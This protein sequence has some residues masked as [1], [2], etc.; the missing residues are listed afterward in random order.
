M[1]S[2]TRI[3]DANQDDQIIINVRNAR[4]V[5]LVF[6]NCVVD[7]FQINGVVFH[8]F[9]AQIDPTLEFPVQDFEEDF[10]VGDDTT[11]TQ[12]LVVERSYTDTAETQEMDEEVF[13]V[14]EEYERGDTQLEYTQTDI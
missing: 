10:I 9:E 4:N 14:D 13:D 12:E 8:R 6:A 11:D 3:I 1:K 2:Q 5:T 7:C